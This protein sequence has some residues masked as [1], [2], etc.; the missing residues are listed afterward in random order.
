MVVRLK[1]GVDN[2]F[3]ETRTSQIIGLPI[4]LGLHLQEL[5]QQLALQHKFDLHEV[6]RLLCSLTPYEHLLRIFRLCVVHAKRNIRGCLVTEEV[7]NLM[8]SLICMVHDDWAGT[9]LAINEQGGKAGKGMYLFIEDNTAYQCCNASFTDWIQDKLRSKFAFAGLCWEKSFIPEEI[10]RAG[11]NNSNLIETVHA[12]VNREGVFCTLVGGV[13]KGEYFDARKMS[14][15][16][17][18]SKSSATSCSFRYCILML[19]VLDI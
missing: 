1:V 5:S 13:K 14:T 4:G 7:R 17:V 19:H 3:V 18:S 6:E 15:L 16:E 12:D 10:W 9:L 8:R 11:D 2:A